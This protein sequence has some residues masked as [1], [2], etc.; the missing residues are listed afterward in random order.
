MVMTKRNEYY[1]IVITGGTDP[2]LYGS[3]PNEA[4]RDADAMEIF[5]DR[6]QFRKEYDGIF[7]ATIK[8]GSLFVDSYVNGE[9]GDE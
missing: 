7:K 1:Y 9:L 2:N 8:D 5:N 6:D 4:A 3:F